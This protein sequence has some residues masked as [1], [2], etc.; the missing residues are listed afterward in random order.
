MRT[1]RSVCRWLNSWMNEQIGDMGWK[2][3][4]REWMDTRLMDWPI[5]GCADEQVTHVA[6]RM[7]RW[8]GNLRNW[9]HTGMKTRDSGK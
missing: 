8:G 3:D 7:C 2:M 5:D 4:K 1:G 6:D 9:C